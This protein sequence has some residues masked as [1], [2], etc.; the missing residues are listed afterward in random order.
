MGM[1]GSM[2]ASTDQG[3]MNMTGSAISGNNRSHM[4]MDMGGESDMMKTKVTQGMMMRWT[5]NGKSYPD[6][7]P[8]DVP[9]GRVVKIR[10]K[11]IDV[12]NEHPMDHPMHLHGTFFQVVSLNGHEPERELWKDT[13]NVPAGEYVD[14]A[15]SMSY[16]GDWM[17]H[18]HI[19]DHEDNGM[20]TVV[21]VR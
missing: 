12:R 18:C 6:T 3:Q 15:F 20:M 16:P 13:L 1:D 7:D 5:I 10:L 9:L 14:I 4:G 8:L 2:A 11:N 19:I 17:L 21:R